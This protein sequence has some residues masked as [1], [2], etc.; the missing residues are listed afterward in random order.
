MSFSYGAFFSAT[1]YAAWQHIPSTYVMCTNDKALLPQVQEA[2]LGAAGDK[3]KIFQ[4]NSGHSPFLSHPDFC[5]DVLLE[6][7]KS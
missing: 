7:A 4:L 2:M 5:V 6:A 3:F 1:R